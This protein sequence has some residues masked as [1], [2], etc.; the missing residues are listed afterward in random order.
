VEGAALR[1]ADL[2]VV[3]GVWALAT[4]GGLLLPT[5]LADAGRAP[6]AR[7]VRRVKTRR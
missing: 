2:A 5:R 4:A 6:L 7:A 1:P 3:S